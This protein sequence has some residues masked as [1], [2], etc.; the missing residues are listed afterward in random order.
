MESLGD[1]ENIVDIL[2]TF[3]GMLL[4]G[5]YTDIILCILIDFFSPLLFEL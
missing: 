3:T 1:K 2:R 4:L 5:S